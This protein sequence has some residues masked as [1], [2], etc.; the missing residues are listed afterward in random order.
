[1]KKLKLTLNKET[2]AKLGDEKLG[3]IKGGEPVTTFYCPIK[4]KGCVTA[5]GQTACT[6]CDTVGCFET[7]FTCASQFTCTSL[8][9][10]SCAC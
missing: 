2:I 4:T 9:E 5:N 1:M 6:P 10:Q 3:L 7:D 8:V